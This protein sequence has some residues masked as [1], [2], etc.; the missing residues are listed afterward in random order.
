MLPGKIKKNGTLFYFDNFFCPG[1]RPD[2]NTR[3]KNS[4]R[5]E[6]DEENRIMNPANESHDLGK[7]YLTTE[8]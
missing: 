1:F 6:R 7:I 5:K 3:S 2:L 8:I 4:T